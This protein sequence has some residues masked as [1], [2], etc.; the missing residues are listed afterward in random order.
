MRDEEHEE[1]NL[2]LSVN[3]VENDDFSAEDNLLESQVLSNNCRDLM[4]ENTEQ[5]INDDRRK[6]NQIGFTLSNALSLPAKVGSL[7]DQIYE[8]DLQF[9]MITETWFTNSKKVQNEIKEIENGESIGLICKNRKG[10]GGGGLAIAY[11]KNKINLK[12]YTIPGNSYEMVCAV[13]NTTE[14]TKKYAIFALYIPPDQKAE[15]SNEMMSCL[16]DCIEKV[17]LELSDPYI[18]IGGGLNKRSLTLQD[19]PDV[20]IVGTAATRN[21]AVLD[22]IA[23]N[24]EGVSADLISPLETDDGRQSDHMTIYARAKLPRVHVFTKDTYSFTK[25]T[26][27]S[28]KMFGEKLALINWE[29]IKGDTTS[30]TAIR[31]NNILQ[32]LYRECF[33]TSTRTRRSCDAPWISK[34]IKRAIRNRKRTFMAQGRSELWRKKKEECEALILEAKTRY[35]AKIKK[36]IEEGGTTKGYYTAANLLSSREAPT[37]WQIQKMFPDLNNKEIAEK[38]AEYFNKI[39]QEFPPVRGPN[40]AAL[41]TP[42]EIFQVSSALKN[43][44]KPKSRVIG[45]IDR[46]LVAKF[47]DLLAIPLHTIFTQVY[48]TLEWPALWSTET[49]HLIPKNGAPDGLKQ[50]HNLSCTPLFS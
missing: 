24:M 30:D 9:S 44:K 1:N 19:F 41:K 37:R 33:I 18:I 26:E 49:V 27:E 31:I 38:A 2:I 40:F 8:L 45:D 20:Q 43:C 25:Y 29:D 11:N 14:E 36:K 10:K 22:V 16:A 23:T 34:R 6:F 13:G 17:K 7:I 4:S 12:K 32:D 39:S 28:E 42:P 15:K 5:N 35:L 3:E 21:N 50:L 46:R 48:E 47:H